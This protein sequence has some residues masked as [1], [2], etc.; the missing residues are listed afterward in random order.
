MDSERKEGTEGKAVPPYLAYRTFRNYI[1]GLKG[2]G[3]P[4]RIDRSVLGNMSGITQSQLLGTLQFLGLIQQDGK[5]TARLQKI[6][7]SE[8]SGRQKELRD[9]LK[10]AYPFLFDSDVDLAKATPRQ[11]KEEFGSFASGQ[12]IR[13]CVAFFI[14]AARDAELPL[15]PHIKA[16][17]A[18][19]GSGQRRKTK[20]GGNGK[21]GQP[22]A[23]AGGQSEPQ[24]TSVYDILI[25]ILD[26]VGM[27]EEE[28]KA[29][30]TLIQYVKKREQE[31]EGD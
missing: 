6:V 10:A 27:N 21:T 18:P 15:S 14:R 31:A 2:V 8:G 22:L 29:I 26:P 25:G 20:T 12:T 16:P 11:I 30:W 17:R 4:S 1:D 3:I 5:P 24:P 28:V 7:D 9:L 19:R 23:P 13:K